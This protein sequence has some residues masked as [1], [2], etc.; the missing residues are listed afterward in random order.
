MEIEDAMREIN[1][2]LNEQPNKEIDRSAL[3]ICMTEL[4]LLRHQNLI[5][6]DIRK[7]VYKELIDEADN[8]VHPSF[9]HLNGYIS[10]KRLKNLASQCT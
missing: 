9:K 2:W 1:K 5:I 10:A 3:A 8:S 4:Y 7:H 6:S